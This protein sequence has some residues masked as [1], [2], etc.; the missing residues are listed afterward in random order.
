[1]LKKI[2]KIT[3]CLCALFI[4][5]SQTV[6]ADSAKTDEVIEKI[7]MYYPYDTRTVSDY[8]S[9]SEYEKYKARGWLTENMQYVHSVDGEKKLVSAEDVRKMVSEGNWYTYPVM[10][11]YAPDGRSEIFAKRDVPAQLKVG[12]YE[13]PVTLMYSWDGKR[14]QIVPTKD[15]A[16]NEAVGWLTHMPTV[17]MWSWDGTRTQVVPINEIEANEAVG[18][19]YGK[20]VRMYADGGREMIVGENRVE[21]YKNLNW[22]TEPFVRMYGFVCGYV[23]WEDVPGDHVASYIANG[24]TTTCPKAEYKFNLQTAKNVAYKRLKESISR[25]STLEVY[26]VNAYDNTEDWERN[27]GHIYYTIAYDCSAMNR[28]GGYSR[29]VICITV[30]FNAYTGD[31]ISY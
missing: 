16:A 28:F 3:L 18:W 21:T 26:S 4:M 1:M 11:L 17:T 15:V 29:D 30:S 6:S 9:P 25:P 2:S 13:E 27:C 8:I 10:K 7:K 24:W 22:S 12:W 20:P 14:T 5:T 19:C 31:Y 23:E